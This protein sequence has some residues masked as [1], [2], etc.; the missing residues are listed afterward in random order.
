[1]A[2]AEKRPAVTGDHIQIEEHGVVTDVIVPLAQS[3]IGG[4]VGAVVAGKLGEK[5]PDPPPPPPA[6]DE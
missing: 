5:P 6:D 1:M 4:A 2:E 3:A